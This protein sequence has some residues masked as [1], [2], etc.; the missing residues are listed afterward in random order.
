MVAPI[1]VKWGVE[2]MRGLGAEPLTKISKPTPFRSS[3]NALFHYRDTPF[4][5]E[6]GG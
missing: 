3:G 1:V 2:G 4:L 6:N 5:E